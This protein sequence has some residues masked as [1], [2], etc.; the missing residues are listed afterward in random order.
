MD[1]QHKIDATRIIINYFIFYNS[2]P[3]SQILNVLNGLHF[4]SEQYN[5]YIF[6][7]F[8]LN[9]NN[10]NWKNSYGPTWFQK[11]GMKTWKLQESLPQ[12]VKHKDHHP[13]Q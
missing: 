4:Q 1:W 13:C 6:T 5:I 2:R 9:Q 8:T 10:K 11:H 12:G 7:Y 3:S